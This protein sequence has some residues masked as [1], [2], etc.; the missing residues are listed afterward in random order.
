M[1]TD[2]KRNAEDRSDWTLLGIGGA[3][4]DRIGHASG[5]FHAGASNPGR[6]IA[7]V[8][9]GALNAL[10]NARLR[11][12]GPV[13]LISARGGDHDGAIVG[14]AIEAAE[15][16]DLSAVFLDRRTASYTAILDESGEQVAG[17]ADMDIYETAL[18]RQLRRKALREA[19]SSARAVLVDANLPATALETICGLAT[20]PIFAIAI[21]P[22]KASRLAVI[23]GGIDTIFMNRREMAAL[24]GGRSE[25]RGLEGLAALGFGRAVVTGGG[26]AVLILDG[27]RREAIVPP[28]PG[29]IADVTGAGDALAGATVA[30]LLRGEARLCEAVRQG[31]AAAQI[32]LLTEG[33]IAARLDDADIDAIAAACHIR[34]NADMET[35]TP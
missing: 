16:A 35:E 31:I 12:V 10:R 2:G 30:A 26:D 9:G 1:A 13:A 32:T 24:T 21:S 25:T 22:A 20:G 4:V 8:G 15:I 19:I 27:A 7:S 14:D 33:P 11:G 17:L 6:L 3:H 29:P 18:P 23:A 5:T 34:Q 28:S